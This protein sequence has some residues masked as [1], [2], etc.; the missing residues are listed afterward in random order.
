MSPEEMEDL[1][2]E[3]YNNFAP[4][5]L[6]PGDPRYVDCR[7]VRG[8]EDVVQDLGRTMR[9]SQAFTYQL[10]SGHRGS[11]KTTELLR[12]KKYLEDRG[13]KV[14]YFAADEED[15]SVQDAQYTDILLACT[16]HLLQELK[17]ADSKPI[18]SW[19][20]DRLQ[21]LQDVMLTEIKI[22][23]L[24]LEVGLQEF[25]KL[26]AAVRTEPRQR[27][28]I[29]ERV[30]PHT[31]TLIEALNAFIADGKKNLPEN[32]KLLVIADS[33]DRIVPI[34]RDNG[35]SNHEEIFLDRNEQLKALN[36]HIVYT[37]PISFIYSR[38]STELKVN[39]GIPQVLPSIMVRQKNDQLYN[40]GLEILRNIIQLRVPL[41]L[42]DTLV[43][44]VFESEE[45]LQDLCLMSGGYVRDLV[46]L[47]QAVITKTDTLPIQARAVQRAV[48][49]LRD[50]YRRA[51]EENQ[52][53]ILREVH[54]S[55]DIENDPIQRS[56]LFSRCLLEYGYFD[57]N[58]DKQTWYDVHPVL[59]KEL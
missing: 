38:W 1:L 13:H 19:L 57:D 44:Q 9:R 48:D 24:N 35:R 34:F 54:Q 53:E 40:K 29:R 43:P 14:V 41:S 28:K 30:E 49:N 52:W 3:M 59:W 6:Q 27:Q 11:G 25:T 2:D 7:A 32:T 20:Q 26:T 23:Q 37:V 15:L 22:D 17:N 33:L 51:V 36:C 58:G 39:Y 4:T 55:K 56:L 12:L 50:V 16:R 45:V 46:Q 47:I 42:R 31:E 8:D 21:D 5:P 18:L 10:Y